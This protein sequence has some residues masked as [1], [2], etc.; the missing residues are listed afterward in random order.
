[1][2][3]ATLNDAAKCEH[4]GRV[5]VSKHNS[6]HSLHVYKYNSLPFNTHPFYLSL[7]IALNFWTWLSHFHSSYHHEL[8]SLLWSHNGCTCVVTH[9]DKHWEICNS[10]IPSVISWEGLK[11]H[12]YNSLQ[13]YSYLIAMRLSTAQS[14]ANWFSHHFRL[15]FINTTSTYI[16]VE[17]GG[18]WVATK[19]WVT[20]KLSNFLGEMA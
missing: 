4:R 5:G 13:I 12:A 14:T 15:F 2:Y 10:I 11:L 7:N 17:D 20:A 18:W 3:I 9:K 1:M 8:L 19:W 16:G 6:Q